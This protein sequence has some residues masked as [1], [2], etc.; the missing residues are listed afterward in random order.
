MT[1]ISSDTVEKKADAG[2]QVQVVFNVDKTVPSGKEG[3]RTSN[4]SK[5]QEVYAKGND[6]L[7]ILKDFL[8]HLSSHIDL[9]IADK[10]SKAF[11]ASNGQPGVEAYRGAKEGLLCFF[12]HG[13]LWANSKPGE[14]FALEDLTRDSD[15]PVLGGVKTLSAT[16]RTLS[17]FVR[18]RLAS[19][20][21]EEAD[22]DVGDEAEFAMIDGRESENIN[23]WIRKHR[24]LFGKPRVAGAGS[25]MKNGKGKAVAGDEPAD[26]EDEDSDKDDEDFEADSDTDGG[27][28]SSGENEEE[29]DSEAETASEDDGEPEDENE[30][31]DEAH[32]PLMRPGAL[33][34]MSKA[35]MDAAVSIVTDDLAG[36]GEDSGPE[37]EEEGDELD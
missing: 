35:A 14:F 10:D 37:E 5:P 36:D 8:S 33:P 16:G 24:N 9:L 3:L 2:E 26:E 17:V 27:E 23:S 34:K 4:G 32:H 15:T 31:L 20:E 21:G 22:E 18:R 28:P 19:S 6:T 1:M 12:P 13:V 7:P 29:N 30:E 11:R 25:P